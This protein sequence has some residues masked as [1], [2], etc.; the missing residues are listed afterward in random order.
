VLD[1]G[2]PVSGLGP[3]KSFAML[4][5][6]AV[7]GRARRDELI[8]LLWGNVPEANARNAFR[9]A[10]H[11]LRTALGNDVI[12][13]DREIV[14]IV[15][16]RID[17][18]RS[19]FLELCERQRWT[20]AA[21]SY[22]GDFLEGFELDES[23]FDRWADTERVRLRTRFEDA[24]RHAGQA[25]LD[26]GQFTEASRWA[27]RMAATAPYDEHAATFEATVLVAAGR[28]N[29]ALSSARRFVARLADDLD[30]PAPPAIEG[31]IARLQRAGAAVS[32][33]TSSQRGRARAN[34]PEFVGRAAELSRMIAALTDLQSDRGA[35]IL[36]E[37]ECGIGKTRLLDEFVRRG[38]TLARALML[39]GR[40]RSLGTALAYG[41][42]ADALRPIVRA[43][44]VAGTSR[45]LM[46]EA[47]RLLP[48]LRDTFDLPAAESLSDDASRVRFFE[49]VGAL[50]ESVAFE[51]PVCILID[52]LHHAS[53]S[54]L[55]LLLYLTGRLQASPV[56]CVL[57]YRADG[58]HA[59]LAERIRASGMASRILV[60]PLSRD[61][62]E[63]LA[64][65][66][67]PRGELSAPELERI[68]RLSNGRPL[69]IIELAHEPLVS[70]RAASVGGAAGSSAN[71]VV[72]LR[73][74]LWA[75]LQT[76]SPA[77]RR[78]FFAA[79]L[80]ERVASLRLL[81]AAAHL[82][83]PAALDAADALTRAGLLAATET[84]YL[85]AHDAT[86]GFIV[87]ASGQ[88]GRA[89]LAGWAAEALS[90]EGE[91]SDAELA[92]LYA[93]A[94]RSKLAFEHAR[95]AAFAA[96]AIGAPHEATRLLTVA[97]TFAPSDAE[98]A[99]IE[100]L[101]TAFGRTPPRLAAV[102]SVMEDAEIIEDV[103]VEDEFQEEP[104]IPNLESRAH[105]WYMSIGISVIVLLL[106]IIA[107]RQI[108]G[109]VSPT[110]M[111]DTLYVSQQTGRGVIP[112]AL[113]V[114]ARRVAPQ[115]ASV[116]PTPATWYDSLRAPLIDALPA[117]D[118]KYVAVARMTP[119][120]K[121]LV[122]VSDDRHDTIAV[123]TG[124]GDNA[125]LDWSPD[126][127][128]L[129]L[130]RGRILADGSIDSDL[131]VFHVAGASLTAIDTAADRS[132]SEARWSPDG[133]RVAW[134]AR[135]SVTRRRDVYVARA[136][137]AGMSEVSADSADNHDVAW[138]PDGT[139]VAFASNLA[140]PRRIYVY[141]LESAHLW[142]VT[143]ADGD[144]H[145]RFSPDGRWLAFEST[146]NGDAGVYLTRPLGGS[147]KRVTPVGA[148][149]AIGRWAGRAPSYIDKLR[150][151]GGSSVGVGDTARL[152]LF[153][154]DQ[155]GSTVPIRDAR[156]DIVDA[157]QAVRNASHNAA[158]PSSLLLVGLRPGDVRVVASIPGW[159]A[160]TISLGVGSSQGFV[161][162][163]SF[164]SGL[165]Q[166]R[167]I[168]LGT[169]SPFVALAGGGSPARALF[170]NGDR[171][172]QS[173]VLLRRAVELRPQLDLSFR[174]I[175]PFA[176]R[177]SSA[178]LTVA[179][180]PAGPFGVV[181]RGAPTFKPLVGVEWDGSSGALTYSVGS[182]SSSDV[183]STGGEGKT[184]ATSHLVTIHIAD[185]GSVAFIVDGVQRW[186]S[187]LRLPGDGDGM[188][189]R[190]WIA[191][192]ASGAIAGVTDVRLRLSPQ[193]ALALRGISK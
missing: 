47:A 27:S 60:G 51:Q 44:G 111:A 161:M 140:G 120:G 43:P 118:G 58:T 28:S 190:L 174:M 96:A 71:A 88:A 46:A 21:E 183:L 86:R 69:T 124:G 76:A 113:S 99:E 123:A 177:P 155:F 172:W 65:Q 2:S 104:R 84:G 67:T 68:A 102:S 23:S 137:G 139:L 48:E 14:S 81:A 116:S 36:V 112:Y 191:G 95:R 178:T 49:G 169:P 132:V 89:L 13:Q 91:T 98:R 135:S 26:A 53:T 125:A 9:Q 6:L 173:G 180:V 34:A 74:I 167:W 64:R 181:D 141:D 148:Q 4:A 159:R 171:E 10:L 38:R 130:S 160:D 16:P 146:R 138:S 114:G 153:A 152:S 164:G 35:T 93:L 117:S 182:D 179:L 19:V 154:L 25:S 90:H 52:D 83:E 142:P 30:L 149:F 175:A 55:D 33:P 192:H 63:T 170:P 108:V 186:R 77:Q 184:G 78:L 143:T 39:R 20:E 162:T 59:G 109:T 122:V 17:V 82:P 193:Q 133:A 107:R 24:L 136:D 163:D 70:E 127:R 56:L 151:I 12:P 110:T 73:D 150:I 61:E 37:G 41:G 5:Y 31:I 103:E 80:L 18:D 15:Q 11:R 105:R 166:Q 50:V 45:H 97:L 126:G 66:S 57:A 129:L 185:D 32:S 115:L 3:G 156:W 7:R 79:S 85:V 75:R 134:V 1:D 121:D 106:G 168:V 40:E 131:L 119:H 72:E 22:P 165:D 158:A 128:A 87:D 92:N 187:M 100:G 8:D 144:G 94:G 176:G 189:A 101:L 145:A 147:I 29:E 188:Q 157:G 54:T 42:I 62:I